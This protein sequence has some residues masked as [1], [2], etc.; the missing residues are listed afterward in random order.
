MSMIILL[1]CLPNA[2][3]I[4]HRLFH[5]FNKCN[6]FITYV[7]MNQVNILEVFRMSPSR[8]FLSSCSITFC[9]F[10]SVL[11][12]RR[13]GHAVL[14]REW[15]TPNETFFWQ[16]LLIKYQLPFTF[17]PLFQFIQIEIVATEGTNNYVC[18]W[19]CLSEKLSWNKT[20]F[21]FFLLAHS[22]NSLWQKET[23]YLSLINKRLCNN[24][25]YL[26]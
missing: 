7:K 18:I 9:T 10:C 5:M 21:F 6:P 3:H 4:I 20:L 13:K 19:T 8:P 2:V 26:I 11:F 22:S 16:Y 23:D 1:T 17:P 24:L 14:A 25:I 15:K 12:C